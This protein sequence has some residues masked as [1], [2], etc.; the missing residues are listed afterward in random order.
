MWYTLFQMMQL[1]DV[2]AI[3]ASSISLRK[4]Q[5]FDC[6]ILDIRIALLQQSPAST[7]EL[8]RILWK[9]RTSGSFTIECASG[10]GT[11][12][13]VLSLLIALTPRSLSANTHVRVIVSKP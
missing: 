6:P 4:K 11:H 10:H 9:L 2:Y 8:N 13:A 1:V 5:L 3:P 7:S 12:A